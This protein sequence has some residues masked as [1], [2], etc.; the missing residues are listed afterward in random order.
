MLGNPAATP[1]SFSGSVG[2]VIDRVAAYFGVAYPGVSRTR[3]AIVAAFGGI[4]A[5]PFP[6]DGAR[7]VLML[8]M[9]CPEMHLA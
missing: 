2:A 5:V 7:D 9:L 1:L 4:E 3:T 8:T 6:A